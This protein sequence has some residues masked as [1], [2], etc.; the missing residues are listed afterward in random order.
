M[1]ALSDLRQLN[2]ENDLKMKVYFISC[3]TQIRTGNK[4][5]FHI[6]SKWHE[7][8]PLWVMAINYWIR[9][10]SGTENALLNEAYRMSQ[11]E[12]QAVATYHSLFAQYTWLWWCMGQGIKITDIQQIYCIENNFWSSGLWFLYPLYEPLNT[13]KFSWVK[14]WYECLI[15]IS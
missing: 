4:W 3:V 14:H 7:V 8:F 5:R 15:S 9:L 1:N 13:K 6:Y 12:K 11:A 2:V 10:N